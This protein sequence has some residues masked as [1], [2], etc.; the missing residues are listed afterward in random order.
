MSWL[1]KDTHTISSAKQNTF[2]PVC[3]TLISPQPVRLATGIIVCVC[4]CVCVCARVCVRVRACVCVS[5]HV[6]IWKVLF[7]QHLVSAGHIFT[8]PPSP[9]LSSPLLSAQLNDTLSLIC[10]F[11]ITFF[12]LI[13]L[14]FTLSM[15]E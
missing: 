6:C 3:Q 9:L 8:L 5:V 2:L 11:F 7:K 1:V 13:C 15:H 12:S 14:F 10:L 4:V